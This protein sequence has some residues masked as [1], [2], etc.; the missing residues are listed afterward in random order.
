MRRTAAIF[1]GFSSSEAPAINLT[2]EVPRPQ[3][4]KVATLPLK[5]LKMPMR[6]TPDA[7]RIRAITF[8]RTK[9]A[10]RTTT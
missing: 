6:P 8:A 2:P 4:A 7:P 5:A 1:A 9:P 10:A 3:P